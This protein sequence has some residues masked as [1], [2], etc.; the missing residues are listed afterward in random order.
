LATCRPRTT[1]PPGVSDADIDQGQTYNELGGGDICGETLKAGV[2]TFTSEIK[3]NADITLK[4]TKDSSDVFIMRTTGSLKQAASTEVTLVDV[5]PENVFWQ[6]AEQVEVG[7]S[8]VLNG[9]I[10]VKTD[11]VFKHSSTLNGSVLAQTACNIK[12]ATIVEP[13]ACDERM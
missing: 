9:I 4:G 3:I 13:E 1:T 6:V 12:V 11:A 8:A 7:A 5:A 2:Y 10:L